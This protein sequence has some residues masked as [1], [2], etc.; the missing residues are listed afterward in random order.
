MNSRVHPNYKTKYSVTNWASYDRALVRQG[1]V[2]VWL[3][4]EAVAGWRPRRAGRPGGQ[5]KYSDLAIQT[6]LTLRLI[7]HLP[8]RQTEGFLTSVFGM[9]DVD[10]DVPDHTTLSR[11]GQ[12]LDVKLRRVAVDEAI[13]LVVD[14][15]GLAIVGKGEWAAAKHGAKSRRGWR[16]L[17]LGVDGSGAILAQVLTEGNADDARTGLRLIDAVEG[18]LASFTADAAYDTIAIYEAAGAR[19]AT[20]V[21]PPTKTATISRSRPRSTA[22]DRTIEKVKE[23]GRRRWKKEMGYHR[24]GRVENAFFRY[25]SIIGDLLRARHPNAQKTEASI[26]C[27]ILNRMFELGAPASVAVAR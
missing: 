20:V 8:L 6:A 22:R 16:K 11:R 21:V 25:K 9:M 1:D 15:T 3:S 13:H 14:S 27:S 19:G 4:P 5:F 7:Y 23:V 26:A 18:D 10:L 17:H 24:Q 12:R 2:T